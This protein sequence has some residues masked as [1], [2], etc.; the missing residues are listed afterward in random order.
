LRFVFEEPES[1][2]L[3]RAWIED[4][5]HS[6]NTSGGITLVAEYFEPDEPDPAA[7]AVSSVGKV[8]MEELSIGKLSV[9]DA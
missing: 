7:E 1:P 5:A 9:A 2:V 4:L 6:A 8:K 3:N